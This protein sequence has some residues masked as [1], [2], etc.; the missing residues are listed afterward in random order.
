MPSTQGD[1]ELGATGLVL[2]TAHYPASSAWC[3][4]TYQAH[5]LSVESA[6]Y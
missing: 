3:F 2:R 1:N 6:T 4:P 5:L